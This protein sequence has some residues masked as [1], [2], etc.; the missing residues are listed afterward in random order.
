MS[1]QVTTWMIA[2]Y[3]A[4]VTVIFQQDGSLLRGKVRERSVVGEFDYWDRLGPTSPTLKTTRHAPTPLVNTPHSR[5]QSVLQDWEWADLVD[6]VDKLKTIH[7][8]ESDYAQNGA[9]SLGREVDRQILVAMQADAR[10]GKSGGTTVTYL[11]DSPAGA[12]TL[13]YQAAAITTP[14]VLTIKLALD[15]K[16]AP[17]GKRFMAVPPA[18]IEQLLKASSAPL[19]SSADYNTIRALV[20]GEL[21]TWVG[22]DWTVLDLDLFETAADAT[23][24]YCYAWHQDAVGLSLAQEIQTDIGIRRDLSNATQVYLLHSFGAVRIM[25]QGVA[26]FI[27]DT[28]N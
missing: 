22:F 25:G 12:G 18:V 21:N 3:Q 26:R 17:R 19:A 13:T 16:I 6:P 5:R 10:A 1:T 7:T 15:N 24:P 8:F 27:V 11:N 23:Q 28:D 2:Q 14:N 20:T 4:N 9:R